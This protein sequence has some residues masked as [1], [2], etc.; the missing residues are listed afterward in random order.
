[1]VTIGEVTS[2]H[3][4]FNH[5]VTCVNDDALLTTTGHWKAGGGGWVKCW[6]LALASRSSG[7]WV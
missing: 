4:N 5:Q 1:M 7:I 2:L 6:F 3:M